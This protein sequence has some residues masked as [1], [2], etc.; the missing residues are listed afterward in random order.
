M[1]IKRESLAIIYV[2]L[3]VI[4]SAG[5]AFWITHNWTGWPFMHGWADVIGLISITLMFGWIGFLKIAPP[6]MLKR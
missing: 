3:G 4:G 1:K 6:S 5:L 2:C